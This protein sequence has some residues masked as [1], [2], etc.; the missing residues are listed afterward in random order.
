MTKENRLLGTVKSE[1]SA[2][3]SRKRRL[4][5]VR[6]PRT[7][8]SWKP[9]S[10]PF[11][12]KVS[13]IRALV[14]AALAV[15]VPAVS[16]YAFTLQTSTETSTE[17]GT[18]TES[19]SMQIQVL[20]T[21]TVA[22]DSN[23]VMSLN[24]DTNTIN[25]YLNDDVT[26]TSFTA[27]NSVL[28][29]SG[30]KITGTKQES[31]TYTPQALLSS[32]GL[33]I[34]GG[35]DSSSSLT[36]D[37]ISTTGTVS[38]GD[39]IYVGDDDSQSVLTGTALTLG[40][41]MTYT[42]S[43]ATTPV[44]GSNNTVVANTANSVVIGSGNTVGAGDTPDSNLILIGSN[45]TTNSTDSVII[46]PTGGTYNAMD[47]IVV[48]GADATVTSGESTAVGHGASAG[49]GSAAFGYDAT[50]TISSL[51]MGYESDAGSAEN[52]TNFAVAIGTTAQATGDSAVALGYGAT[53]T[54][55]N[56]VAIGRGAGSDAVGGTTLGHDAH[57]WTE[58]SVALGINSNATTAAGVAGWKPTGAQ[59]TVSAWESTDGPVSIGNST[60][61]YTR[62]ITNVAA[63]TE[64]TDAANI[65]QLKASNI[66][67]AADTG[68]A[69]RVLNSKQLTVTGGATDKT[70]T[71]NNISVGI[72]SDSDTGNSTLSVALVED[73]DLGTAGSV[74]AGTF[75][76][77]AAAEEGTT[78]PKAV[79]SS[80]GLVISDGVAFTSAA[81]TVPVI[82]YQNSV[83]G[84]T[85]SDTIVLGSTN[86]VGSENATVSD[87]ILLGSGVSTN[88]TDSVIINPSGGTYTDLSN[89]TVIGSGANVTYNGATAVG[90]EAAAGENSA[91][92]GY[93][94]AAQDNSTAVGYGSKAGLINTAT[95]D[96][97]QN[98]GSVAVGT[99]AN[100]TGDSATAIGYGTRATAED[101][102]AI[103]RGAAATAVGA[104]AIGHESIASAENGVALG[105]N[106]VASTASG[107]TGW[108]PTGDTVSGSTW[109]ST[110]GA[111]SVGAKANENAYH[112]AAITRQITNVAAGTA[113]TDAVN[114]AQ[115]KN[116]NIKVAGDTGSYAIKNG[117]TLTIAGDAATGAVTADGNILTTQDGR[118]L[119]LSLV[120]DVDL[121]STGSLTVGATALDNAGV[122]T[123]GG[124]FT[125][126]AVKAE[127]D[128][129]AAAAS[130]SSSGLTVTS[131]TN[132]DNPDA[133]T[134]TV[135]SSGIQAGSADNQ[136]TTSGLTASAATIAGA[137]SAGSVTSETFDTGTV[138]LTDSGLTY[139]NGMVY[140]SARQSVPVIG[141]NNSVVGNA[142]NSIVMGNGNTAGDSATAAT[143]LI[144]LGNGISSDSSNSVI[145][146]P[147]GGTYNDLIG[148]VAIG[149]NAQVKASYGTAVG[150]NTTAYGSGTAYGYGSTAG[151]NAVAIGRSAYAYSDAAA[152][153]KTYSDSVAV[154]DSAKATGTSSVS[155]GQASQATMTGSTAIGY[156]A[157]AAGSSLNGS[158]AIGYQA[159][160]LSGQ[161]TAIGY[162]ATAGN[163]TMASA[164]AIGY[165]A[166]AGGAGSTAIGMGAIAN[167]ANSI[168]IGSES[169][170]LILS[171]VQGWDPSGANS[172]SSSSTWR[173]SRAALSV[174]S[175]ANSITRQITNVAAGKL[176]TDA[177]NVAQL[178]N[179]NISFAGDTGTSMVKNANTV[180]IK[181]GADSGET[182]STGNI[183]VAS[184]KGTLTVSLVK[185]V[186]LGSTGSLTIGN[187]S[188]SDTGIS[189]GL[190]NGNPNISLTASSGIIKATRLNTNAVQ[191]GSSMLWNSSGINMAGSPITGLG[192][193]TN[194]IA[195]DSTDAVSGGAIWSYFQSYTPTSSAGWNAK[196]GET[197]S[198]HVAPGGALTYATDSNL[199]LALSDAGT[200]TVSTSATP[201]YTSVAAETFSTGDS[202]LTD[203]GLATSGTV[204]AGTATAGSTLA[205]TGLT[206]KD[207]TNTASVSSTGFTAGTGNSLTTS[208]LEATSAAVSGTVTVGSTGSET[209]ISG[210]TV[211]TETVQTGATS[212][213]DAGVTTTG[214][215]NATGSGSAGAALTSSGLTVTTDG[216][217]A[218]T[219]TLN[220]SGLTVGT[221][222]NSLT[223]TGLAASAAA[224]TGTLTFGT[225]GSQTTV[226]GNTITTG[227]VNASTL[228]LDTSNT[229]NTT[230]GITASAATIG[231]VGITSTGLDLNGKTITDITSGS[232]SQNS[233]DAV[234]GGA[235]WSELQ[236]YTTTANSGWTAKVGDTT[237]K[238]NPNGALTY[239][240]DSNL[241]VALSDKG[242][243]T[244]STSAN[245]SYT[246]VA[247]A[248]SVTVGNE[249][250]NTEIT[251]TGVTSESFSTG[252]S[253]LTDSGLTTTG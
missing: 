109:I 150:T 202:S 171:G 166:K 50:A 60:L 57:A 19:S 99:D 157:S 252:A 97:T 170:A 84:S 87:L 32:A 137:L 34:T 226:S 131:G 118:K 243:L 11:P 113:D 64:D 146:N 147:T 235:V 177:V 143:G 164:T 67:V 185:D 205:S 230:D 46:S 120:E 71:S 79:L 7:S 90:A 52:S 194:G 68:T 210:S 191:V 83:S 144:M 95:N 198:Y 211:T 101:T 148:L 209:T 89:I 154:G 112:T 135:T 22:R 225:I 78:A 247:A 48:I 153:A 217:D 14:I 40:N 96:L 236:N 188:I 63:G 139:D 55:N 238:V 214:T 203:S 212:L 86:T 47:G 151:T 158:T 195:Q 215:L 82:G 80:S 140:T 193:G 44:I 246:T 49:Q 18:E 15:T 249:T 251:G 1:F 61:G 92:F 125:A 85:L 138:T 133:V 216:T 35:T 169:V 221:S 103:G 192:A 160:A 206:V 156:Q 17:T 237:Y 234:S 110:D 240:T 248:T 88:A 27:G 162:G 196:V 253:V 245:P 23:I 72:T 184:S 24:D 37:G 136:L 128:T 228:S 51:A 93:Q 229:W 223:N 33:S 30:L 111:V 220:A 65:A 180:T 213:S 176:D 231:G 42:S 102:V 16:A 201:S 123:T 26:G 38:A 187:T 98:G 31:D 165:N 91:A 134:T 20:E 39:S 175:S 81:T 122:S 242:V 21:I 167:Q 219:A 174:G 197:S 250:S 224:V 200:L 77:E 62:Q 107:V 241:S 181:G 58:N 178:I 53:A 25:L 129:T 73:V 119:T 41:G 127:T 183:S 28:S 12:G 163:E 149:D 204:L 114:V 69:A 8:Q 45:T 141:Y 104:S 9:K 4:T 182:A 208:G 106:S 190:T 145:I 115:L 75:T 6:P 29:T 108:N 2:G 76:A 161:S 172:S 218:N 199:S 173:S 155:I 36:P 3:Q 121:G 152:A 130:L 70:L 100:A 168:A 74:T 222:G 132:T 159:K 56:S 142:T 232:I 186:D 239:A 94:A 10:D 117:E 116:S 207:A 66:A 227:T 5:P 126:N 105:I 59:S 43:S 13:L 244:V 179:S 233:T 124:T 54:K 189:L